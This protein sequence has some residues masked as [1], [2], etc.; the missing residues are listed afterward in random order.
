MDSDFAQGGLTAEHNITT[1][2]PLHYFKFNRYTIATLKSL[3]KFQ[4]FNNSKF[5]PKMKNKRQLGKFHS[6]LVQKGIRVMSTTYK[7]QGTELS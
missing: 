1:I 4:S 6:A 3:L 2:Q 5:Y 7:R